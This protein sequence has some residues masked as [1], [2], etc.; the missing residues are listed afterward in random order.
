MTAIAQGDYARRPSRIGGWDATWIL[1]IAII[2]VLLFLV[3]SPF[4]YLI[5]TSFQTERTGAFTLQN[6][7]TAYGRARYV[8][9]LF[10]SLKLGAAPPYWPASSPCRSPGPVRAP[11]CRAAASCA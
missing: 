2:A 5:L 9:A 4:V 8:D 7:A 11:T 3:V 10:N 6:Y 1:W